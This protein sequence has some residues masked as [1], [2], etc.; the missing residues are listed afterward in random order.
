MSLTEAGPKRLLQEMFRFSLSDS[1]SASKHDVDRFL[2]V[3]RMTETLRFD[4]EKCE[5]KNTCPPQKDVDRIENESRDA[6]E[7]PAAI[8]YSSGVCSVDPCISE[9]VNCFICNCG[10]MQCEKHKQVSSSYTRSDTCDS[11]RTLVDKNLLLPITK[12]VGTQWRN[13]FWRT[14]LIPFV[15]LLCTTLCNADS[16]LCAIGLKTP[17]S[18]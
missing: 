12:R 18:E 11:W 14:F 13:C 10:M 7:F 17:G 8:K 9:N 4:S 3:R 5:N 2:D 16:N 6:A 15:I 1:E